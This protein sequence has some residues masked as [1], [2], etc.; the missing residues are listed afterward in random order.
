MA[1]VRANPFRCRMW[2][3]HDRL[4]GHI[5][6]DS[7]RIEIESIASH[8]QLIPA[9]ARPV[10][11]HPEIHF[12]LI[13]G[14]RRL[15]I[16]RHINAEILLDVRPLTDQEALVAMDIENRQRRDISAYERGRS[17]AR[18]LRCGLFSSQEELA[19]KLKNS[20][21]SVS[22]LL[23]VACL[24]AVVVS[25]FADATTI[26]ESW[27]VALADAIEQADN[28]RRIIARARSLA[29]RDR[30]PPE[31]VYRELLKA[32]APGRKSRFPVRH[33][34]VTDSSGR[35]LFRLKFQRRSV[36]FVL[37]VEK[38]VPP[39]LQ[40]LRQEFQRALQ[41]ETRQVP[42]APELLPANR[43]NGRG[44][45]ANATRGPAAESSPPPE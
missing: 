15:F 38:A 12:E 22:R 37:D 16:A 23:K 14:A 45:A 13:Y 9:L 29:A 7:C 42:E 4:E 3:L 19:R 33:E 8:G 30:L 2:E 10:K 6:E 18:W 1:T 36:A 21:A 31:E 20:P 32:A 43:F 39:V 41:G 17:Y 40:R 24:P 28:R 27:G 11:D 25:A 35:P 44:R 26:R 5:S 34:V